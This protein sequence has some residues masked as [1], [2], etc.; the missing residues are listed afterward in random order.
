MYLVRKINLA[1]IIVIGDSRQV[2]NKMENGSNRGM[3]KYKIIYKRIQHISRELK[4]PIFTFSEAIM[5][6]WINWQIKELIL[7]WG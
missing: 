3:I 6:W 4:I 1:K 2:I 5:L 7:E